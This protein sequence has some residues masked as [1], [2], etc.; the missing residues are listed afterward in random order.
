MLW[1]ERGVFSRFPDDIGNVPDLG[2]DIETTDQVPVQKRYNAI[3][4][5]LYAEVKKHVQNM[6]DRGWITKSKSLWSSPV[7]ITKKKNGKILFA[8]IIEWL[9]NKY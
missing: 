4:R 1:Q 8:W 6:L 7:V 9:I 2:L 5:T 3:P